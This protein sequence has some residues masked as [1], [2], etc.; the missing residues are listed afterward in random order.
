[1]AKADPIAGSHARKRHP[2]GNAV[3]LR[4][5]LA[6]NGVY[7]ELDLLAD[8]DEPRSYGPGTVYRRAPDGTLVEL[9]TP[10]GG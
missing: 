3:G 6:A 7:E 10:M 5:Q 9:C 1:M 8:P 2:R 4:D